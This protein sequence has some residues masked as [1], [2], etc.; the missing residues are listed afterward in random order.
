MFTQIFEQ[1]L[2]AALI[3]LSTSIFF[4]L[5]RFAP[6]RELPHSSGW[7]RRAVAINLVQLALIGLGGL[8]KLKNSPRNADFPAATRSA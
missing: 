6:G 1:I 4:V 3:V 8:T 7:Y 5:E 2:P